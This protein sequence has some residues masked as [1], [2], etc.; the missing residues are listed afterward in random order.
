MT[1][2]FAF[3]VTAILVLPS[4]LVAQS[5]TVVAGRARFDRFDSNNDGY[6][7][8]IELAR[9]NCYSQDLD[10]DNVVNFSEFQQPAGTVGRVYRLAQ[11]AGRPLPYTAPEDEGS[12]Q[13]LRGRMTLFSNGVAL[14]QM[15]AREPGGP[16][17]TLVEGGR[18]RMVGDTLFLRMDGPREVR[19]VVSGGQFRVR[20]DERAPWELWRQETS[21]PAGQRPRQPRQPRQP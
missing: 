17:T 7:H 1:K 12:V 9:C 18:Y 15:T 4:S 21:T 2:R 20:P 3:L 13:L 14:L 11:V 5:D 10:G 8:G 6:V 16:D 19:A